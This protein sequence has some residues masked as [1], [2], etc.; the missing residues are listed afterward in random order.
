MVGTWLDM[1]A[2]ATT[3]SSSTASNVELNRISRSISCNSQCPL[4]TR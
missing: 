4:K 2:V 3:A 1:G